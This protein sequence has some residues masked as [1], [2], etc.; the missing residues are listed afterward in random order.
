MWWAAYDSFAYILQLVIDGGGSVNEAM[1]F[2]E[3]PLMAIVKYNRGEVAAQLQMLLACPDL[4]LDAEYKGKTA[5]EWAVSGG[6]L[7][8]AVAIAQ[9]RARRERWSALRATWT[10]A[11]IALTKAT[12]FA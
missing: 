3:T 8:L 7:E 2:G 11:V 6:R 5:E 1:S 4:D 9:Q 10:A 12:I